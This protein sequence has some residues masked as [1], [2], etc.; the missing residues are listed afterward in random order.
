MKILILNLILLSLYRTTY[1]VIVQNT[2]GEC[3]CNLELQSCACV[4]ISADATDLLNLISNETDLIRLNEL[5]LSSTLSISVN[6]TYSGPIAEKLIIKNTKTVSTSGFTKLTLKQLVLQN[7]YTYQAEPSGNV[8]FNLPNLKI[9]EIQNGVPSDLGI[10]SWSI[11]KEVFLEKLVIAN[12]N[13]ITINDDFLPQLLHLITLDLS[14]NKFTTFSLSASANPSLETLILSNNL[15]EAL[16][17]NTFSP[18]ANLKTIDLSN[19]RITHMETFVKPG[20]T[21]LVYILKGNQINCGV[22]TMT[23]IQPLVDSHKV[24]FPDL[25]C[26]TPVMLKG[27]DL[28]NASTFVKNYCTD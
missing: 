4:L 17:P 9:L 14:N 12:S 7:G 5:E 8:I 21:P 1:C 6:G 15:I 23:V 13:L 2:A 19:N 11:N 20:N 26:A 3:N 10:P 28:K 24:G 22:H 18:T 25:V 16:D 27:Y